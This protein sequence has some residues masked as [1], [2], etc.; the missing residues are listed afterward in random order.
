MEFALTAPPT[1]QYD[2][3]PEGTRLVGLSALVSA[4][5]IEAPVRAICC[6][7]EKHV[8]DGKKNEGDWKVFDKRYW[9]GDN[10]GDHI[11]F[12]LKHENI[13][14]LVLKRVFDAISP[15]EMEAFV[16][17]SPTGAPSRRG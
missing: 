9:P 2:V 6:V 13:D 8:R 15:K 12:A 3:V 1:F 4:L 14:L 16:Q 11:T 7:S 5:E 10:F 17:S